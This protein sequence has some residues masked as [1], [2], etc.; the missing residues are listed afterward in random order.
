MHLGYFIS[1]FSVVNMPFSLQ[2][3]SG[4]NHIL[5][6]NLIQNRPLHTKSNTSIYANVFVNYFHSHRRLDAL[7]LRIF[8][9]AAIYGDC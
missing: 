7:L 4:I 5:V 6:W 2:N 1:Y 9:A 8:C 3:I